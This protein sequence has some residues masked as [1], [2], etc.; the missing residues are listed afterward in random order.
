MCIVC[1]FI[2]LHFSIFLQQICKFG[3]IDYMSCHEKNLNKFRKAEI[4]SSIFSD[5]KGMKDQL[6]EENQKTHKHI[7]VKWHATK[8]W[9][10]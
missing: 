7:K 1:P 2:S 9:K 10:D 8:W 4:T 5:H 6:Q 3:G